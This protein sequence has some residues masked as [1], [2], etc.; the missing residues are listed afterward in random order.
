MEQKKR[1]RRVCW[2]RAAVLA[3]ALLLLVLGIWYVFVRVAPE[4]PST[5]DAVETPAASEES[6]G[7]A[8]ESA[9]PWPGLA[10]E[11]TAALGTESAHYA[12]FYQPLDASQ[13]FV[14]QSRPMRSASMIKVFLLAK[15]M[16][17]VRA[18]AAS[19]DETITLRRADKVGGAGSLAGWADGSRVTLREL[20]RL[21]ITES[22]NTATNLVID[23]FGM[24]A[25]NAYI[26]RE[27]Y[28]DTRLARKM[29]DFDAAR[30]GRENMT[31]ARDLGR[32]FLRLATAYEAGDADAAY[33]MELLLAQT[34]TEC[35][36][37]ALPQLRIAHKTGEL[38]GLYDD[39]GIIFTEDGPV[40]LCML[41]DGLA[42][43]SRNLHVMRRLSERILAEREF[44]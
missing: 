11:V 31:S 35:L 14:Y 3:I 43:R 32:F 7:A 37:E 19:L 24:D 20:L 12:V 22:D 40:V 16:E 17:D 34:D 9:E 38:D 30:A 18:G 27:G 42:D 36:P 15:A 29:M 28:D 26:V 6:A 44:L 10:E 2:G 23:R 5:S 8:E 33:M 21:M 4:E 25:L 13:P 1:K 39:G 41:S